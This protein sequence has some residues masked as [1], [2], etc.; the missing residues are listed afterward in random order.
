M[1]ATS[2]K[3]LS[4]TSR[5]SRPSDFPSIAPSSMLSPTSQPRLS[6]I[7]SIPCRQ[8]LSVLLSR[9]KLIT[10]VKRV[11]PRSCLSPAH[12]GSLTAG[13]TL[14]GS[15]D[16][17]LAPNMARPRW[18]D[19]RKGPTRQDTSNGRQSFAFREKREGPSV[20]GSRLSC[21]CAG[22][23]H[24][25]CRI[26]RSEEG[27]LTTAEKSDTSDLLRQQTALAR[28]GELALRSDN[29]DEILTEACRLVGEALGTD[30][31]KVMELQD[32]GETLRV[33]AGVGW[34]PGVVGKATS[35]AA[36]RTSEGHALKTG[37]PMISPDIALVHLAGR[38]NSISTA[39]HA[40]S[41]LPVMVHLNG[42]PRVRLK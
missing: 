36:D 37:R 1:G 6:P 24:R 12:S 30:L 32:D 8:S 14:P 38:T 15:L 28:F 3:P 35:K 26:A 21:L 7:R 10:R 20:S 34:K 11:C 2:S 19:C 40:A 23:R 33:R 9:E 25:Q 5:N 18:P 31:A 17:P 4:V 22:Q 41:G 39:T 29:L 27:S 13:G 16:P 42:L